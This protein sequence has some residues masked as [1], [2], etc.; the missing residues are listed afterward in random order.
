MQTGPDDRTAMIR[1]AHTAP[2]P[3][4][5]GGA[6]S[7]RRRNNPLSGALYF[8][9]GCAIVTR[10]GIRAYVIVPLMINVG[11]FAA[12]IYF[13]ASWLGV[14]S[15]RMLPDWLDFLSWILAPILV[16]SMLIAGFFA[17]NLV[18]NLIAAPFNGL[19]AEVVER[20]LT[21]REPPPGS[22]LRALVTGL[23]TA[24]GAE[25]RKFVYVTVRMLPLLVLFLVPGVNIVAP[26][27]WVLLGAWMLAITYVDYPM[28]NHGISFA[29]LRRRL[30]NR[31]LLCL[32]FGAAVM[33][34]LAVPGLNFLVIPCAVAGASAMWVEQFEGDGDAAPTAAAPDGENSDL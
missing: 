28:A 25:A 1:D 20:H 24:L 15:E 32:G 18:A 19:L 27:L 16:L 21:G 6:P 22:G 29:E 2:V 17:S 34:A 7:R 13:G 23:G 12:L 10:P 31:R 4:R 30:R 8:L 9:R 5:G 33:A 11:L 14:F 26:V 3:L